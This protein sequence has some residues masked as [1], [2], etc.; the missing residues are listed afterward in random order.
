MKRI[1]DKASTKLST[2]IVD[3]KHFHYVT[4]TYPDF[5]RK[6]FKLDC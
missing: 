3:N 1:F 5:A 4:T 2:G 6:G